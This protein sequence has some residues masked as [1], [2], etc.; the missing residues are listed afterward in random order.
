MAK[1][2]VILGAGYAGV[3]TA[4]KLEKKFRKYSDVNIT[5]IDK[6]PYHTML[7]ELHEVAANRTPESHIRISLSKIFAGRRVNVKLDTVTAIDCQ[8]KCLIGQVGTYAYDYLVIS[9][10]SKPTYFKT[11]G[12]EENAFKL[13]SYEDAVRLKHHILDVF[14]RSVTETDPEKRK[15][16]LTFYVVGAGFTGVEMVGE[17]AEWIPILCDEFEIDPREVKIANVDMLNR[18]VPTFPEGISAKAE[19]RLRR[20][21]VEV[22]LQTG[23]CEVGKDYIDLKRGEDCIRVSTS[24]VIWTAGV[25]GSEVIQSSQ[26]LEKAGRARLRT[27]EYLRAAGTQG[28]YVAGDN[29]F[30]IPEGE[31]EPVPQMVENAEQS[32]HTV[33]H[34]IAAEITQT[35]SL[36][37][38]KPAFHGAML[39]I[40][41]RYGAAYVGTANR[42][43]SLASFFAMFAKHFINLIYFI[44]V[45]G[46]YKIAGYLKNEFFTVRNRRSFVGGHFSNRTPSFMLVPLRL[47]LG[48]V[49]IFEGVKKIIEGWLTQPKLKDFFDSATSWFDAI[50]QGTPPDAT[51][52]ATATG[53]GESVVQAGQVLFN[54][55]FLG[56]FK[57]IFV[58][59]KPLTDA[60]LNDYAFKLDIGL[61]NWFVSNVIVANPGVSLFMQISI[62]FVEIL[63]GL[64]LMGGLLTGVSALVSLVLLFM[65]ATTTGL[66]LSS[67]WMGFAAIAM[68]F[69]A[70]KIFGL[71]YYAL[72]IVGRGWRRIGWVRRLYLYHD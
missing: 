64:S 10:G 22:V 2:I 38:Y 46:W 59:G 40:G 50:V 54:I 14:N 15:S 27:D 7:T 70:G 8:R 9:A 57:A 41:S 4:K 72:P 33:A 55:N 53:G 23:V 37:K 19:K 32:A 44:Q 12:A 21:G 1:N 61:M 45:A 67:F 51:S 6:H 60:T 25:E 31:N 16:L 71:D 47:F 63:I 49:W 26:G 28:V 35:G 24:T 18:A 5:V 56:I 29:I 65:F 69:G 36:E 11:P 68:L 42:K 58:S 62:V 3:L 48:A 34:N 52:S 39:S 13:W 66:Y 43:F 17:L 20:M 30:Y